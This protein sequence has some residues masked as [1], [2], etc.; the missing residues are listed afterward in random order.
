MWDQ[1]AFNDLAR[2]GGSVRH[3]PNMTKNLWR[4]DNNKLTLGILPS[5]IFCSGHTFF[6][7]TK[8]KEYGLDPYVAHATFQYS[9]TPGKRNRFREFLLWEDPPE[10]FT[11]PKGF[12]HLNFEVPKEMMERSKGVEGP[13]VASKLFNHFELVH[14]QLFRIRVGLALATLTG[15]VLVLPPIWCEIDKYWAPLYD[16]NIP[17]SHFIKPFICPMDHVLD[18]EG[19]WHRE[20]TPD[21]GPHVNWR[22]YSFFNNPRLTQEVNK[23]RLLMQACG[24]D[25]AQDAKATEV[26]VSRN[27]PASLVNLSSSCL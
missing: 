2:A 14:W 23:S 6:V 10:Y 26:K 8:Y 18:I 19:W 17:G 16:G 1:T 4:G 13:M 25:C 21:F 11:H 20:L 12:I 9:G 7:Q 3:Q 5:S 15:R 24:S 27:D 22:E